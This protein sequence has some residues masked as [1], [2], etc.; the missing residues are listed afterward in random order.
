MIFKTLLLKFRDNPVM[1]DPLIAAYLKFMVHLSD[2]KK[3]E[4]EFLPN[5]IINLLESHYNILNPDLR[6]L[7]V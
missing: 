3:T 4:L 5:E 7:L 2:I 6:L 1:N